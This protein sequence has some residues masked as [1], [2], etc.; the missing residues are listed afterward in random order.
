[1]TVLLH[2]LSMSDQH[3]IRCAL[4]ARCRAA[5]DQH[6]AAECRTASL[7]LTGAV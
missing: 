4:L 5:F 3:C 7:Y 2:A 1:M 6:A